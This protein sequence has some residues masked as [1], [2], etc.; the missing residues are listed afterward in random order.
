MGHPPLLYTPS[1]LLKVVFSLRVVMP[2]NNNE[3]PPGHPPAMK[4]LSRNYWRLAWV[5]LTNSVV[6]SLFLSGPIRAHRE[7]ELLYQV[8]RTAAPPFSYVHEF[9]SDP[10]R[11]IIVATLLI[12]IIAELSGTILSPIINLGPYVVWLIMFLWEAV[13]VASGATPSEVSPGVI[14]VLIVIPLAVV[15]AVDLMFY[16]IAFRRRQ[17]GW[18]TRILSSPVKDH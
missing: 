12:G 11:P 16:V 13:R 6:I 9:F 5:L 18:P 8:M 10:W 15:V 7:Q 14:M 4:R 3:N 2:T 17:G 1:G